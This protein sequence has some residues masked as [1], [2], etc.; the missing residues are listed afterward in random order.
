MEMLSGDTGFRLAMA[1]LRM[2]LAKCN[3]ETSLHVDPPPLAP[4]YPPHQLPTPTHGVLPAVF[5]SG[6][7]LHSSVHFQINVHDAIK[8]LVPLLELSFWKW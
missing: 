8:K 4:F 1:S 6:L 2:C 3:M 7:G 5:G